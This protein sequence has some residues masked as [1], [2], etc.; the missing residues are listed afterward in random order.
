M[1]IIEYFSEPTPITMLFGTYT[2]FESDSLLDAVAAFREKHPVEHY[3]I[4]KMQIVREG[5]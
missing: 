5:E 1:I 2:Y 4:F 3:T